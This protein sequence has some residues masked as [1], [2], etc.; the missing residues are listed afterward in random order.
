MKKT[1]TLDIVMCALFTALIAVGAYIKIPLPYVPITLQV[2][3][4]VLAGLLLG[5]KLGAAASL[6]YLVIGLVG[7]PIFTEGGGP[8]YIFKPSFGYII[9]FVIGAFVIGLIAHKKK[10][11]GYGRLL[12]AC[13]VG[14][15]IIYLIGMV[16]VYLIKNLYLGEQ[17]GLW[18]LFL[19]C[20]L[21]TIPGDIISCLI[22]VLIAK[23]MIPFLNRITA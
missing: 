15:L 20:F 13:F 2:F 1:R 18:P 7:V 19:Y 17:M 11:P 4:V 21:L 8:G 6:A 10:S 12:V 9:G 16:Y 5:A 14:L 22:C 3:F 23:R